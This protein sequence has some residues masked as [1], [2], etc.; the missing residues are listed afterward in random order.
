MLLITHCTNMISAV[1][2]V[3]ICKA[4]RLRTPRLPPA[5]P[6]GSRSP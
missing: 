5:V 3:I 1:D 2:Q 4:T 6:S